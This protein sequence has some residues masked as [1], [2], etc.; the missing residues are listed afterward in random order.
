MPRR[1]ISGQVTLIG[2]TGIIY[3]ASNGVYLGR[4]TPR[5]LRLLPDGRAFNDRSIQKIRRG[6]RGWRAAANVLESFGATPAPDDS[7][8]R[9]EWLHSALRDLT[10][11]MRHHGCHKYAWHSR[12]VF[13]AHYLPVWHFRRS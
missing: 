2:H 12:G 8:A 3:Q 1:D 4:G 7:E 11:P 9:R 6:E 13:G 5:T 10:R